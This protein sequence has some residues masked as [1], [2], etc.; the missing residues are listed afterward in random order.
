[1]KIELCIKYIYK[2]NLNKI[3]KKICLKNIFD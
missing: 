2:F 1:M 3:L